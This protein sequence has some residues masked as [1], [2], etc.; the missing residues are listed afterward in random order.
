M[1]LVYAAQT[2]FDEAVSQLSL[3]LSQA[4]E[5]LGD[6]HPYTFD[7]LNG[8]ALAMKGRGDVVKAI[9]L[10]QEGFLR[11]TR[12]LDRVL[13]VTGENAREGYI[14]LHRPELMTYLSN[15]V[16]HSDVSNA[17]RALECL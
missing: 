13:W 3:V 15:L 2:R 8:L 6:E 1:G 9:E 4:E 11:R 16:V 12:F 10:Q 17:R 7:A 5:T 14:R